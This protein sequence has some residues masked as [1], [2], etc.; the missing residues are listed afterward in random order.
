MLELCVITIFQVQIDIQVQS[1]AKA[2]E[3]HRE[4]EKFSHALAGLLQP[5]V[6]PIT[7]RSREV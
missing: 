2:N 6:A 4:S 3:N 5:P 7:G 1:D